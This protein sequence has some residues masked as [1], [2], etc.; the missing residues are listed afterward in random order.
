MPLDCG[1]REHVQPDRQLL[2]PTG[3]STSRARLGQIQQLVLLERKLRES[4]EENP[5]TPCSS[6]SA[7]TGPSRKDAH[8][9]K[10][11]APCPHGTL[12]PRRRDHL[13]VPQN[14]AG[15]PSKASRLGRQG[16]PAEPF[17][18]RVQLR[19]AIAILSSPASASP[20][21]WKSYAKS[22][23]SSP[24]PPLSCSVIFASVGVS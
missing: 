15:F 10:P 4:N 24:W 13:R 14:H 20:N 21:F 8:N 5:G 18:V 12:R 6:L 9:L 19:E 2:L 23:V 7:T 11:T 17:C 1:P 3:S 16:P 22:S